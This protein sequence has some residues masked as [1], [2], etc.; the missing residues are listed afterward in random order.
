MITR[1]ELN[2]LFSL[3]PELRVLSTYRLMELPLLLIEIMDIDHMVFMLLYIDYAIKELHITI[4]SQTKNL[5]FH[6]EHHW[7]NSLA[8]AAFKVASSLTHRA[9]CTAHLFITKCQWSHLE[10]SNILVSSRIWLIHSLLQKLF[11]ISFFSLWIIKSLTGC[12]IEMM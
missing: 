11:Y 9:K 8:L 5:R 3:M 10:Y 2:Q 12:H 1:N 6:N 7:N 4:S